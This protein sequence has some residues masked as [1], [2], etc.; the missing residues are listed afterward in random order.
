VDAQYGGATAVKGYFIH[1]IRQ[2]ANGF[3]GVRSLEGSVEHGTV[4]DAEVPLQKGSLYI[5]GPIFAEETDA[6][7]VNAQNGKADIGHHVGGRKESTVSTHGEHEVRVGL[8]IVFVTDLIYL[9][10][11]LFQ[12]TQKGGHPLIGL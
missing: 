6:A 8:D 12:V 1:G 5:F 4:L 3:A 7:E 11:G 9:E 10:G 2:H